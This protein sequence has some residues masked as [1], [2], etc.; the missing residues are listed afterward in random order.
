VPGIKGVTTPAVPPAVSYRGVGPWQRGGAKPSGQPTR[1]RIGGRRGAT[2]SCDCQHPGGWGPGGVVGPTQVNRR[3]RRHEEQAQGADR[4]GLKG[5]WPGWAAHPWYV[6]QCL[7]RM[8]PFPRANPS[9]PSGASS[10][11]G[12]GGASRCAA[13][14]PHHPSGGVSNPPP[15]NDASGLDAR[16]VEEA[17][18]VVP[19]PDA[20]RL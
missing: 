11:R 13:D 9:R 1:T 5:R 18:A 7:S 12:R 10:A 16:E 2:R 3:K 20:V 15:P 19:A 14:A 8:R 17:I 4:L 6:S